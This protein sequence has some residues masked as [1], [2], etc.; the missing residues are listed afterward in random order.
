MCGICGLATADGTSP[1]REVVERMSRTL[2]HRGPDSDGLHL[3]G[4]VALAARRLSIIDL[5]GG[6]QPIANEDGSVVVVLY[7][8]GS[9]KMTTVAAAGKKLQFAM[10]GSGWATVVAR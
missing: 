2:R 7:N 10:P 4:P 5:E 9:A 3:R 6:T 1:D 8:A